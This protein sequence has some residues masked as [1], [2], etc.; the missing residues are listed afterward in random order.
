MDS[1]PSQKLIFWTLDRHRKEIPK[2][3]VA[4]HA[5][6]YL[7]M[8]DE[9]CYSHMHNHNSERKGEELVP[10][11]RCCKDGRTGLTEGCNRV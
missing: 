4:C 3:F 8:K 11:S 5:F 6:R 2:V 9:Y 1:A 10:L 7:H